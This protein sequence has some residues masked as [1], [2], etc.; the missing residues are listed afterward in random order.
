MK[1]LFR[2]YYGLMKALFG[3]VCD[4]VSARL[5][6]RP[7]RLDLP[8]HTHTPAHTHRDPADALLAADSRDT[9]PKKRKKTLNASDASDASSQECRE[10]DRADSRRA[11]DSRAAHLKKRKK[12]LNDSDASESSDASSQEGRECDAAHV[13][14][15][16]VEAAQVMDQLMASIVNDLPA[17]PPA[18]PPTAVGAP[19]ANTRLR[20]SQMRFEF[21]RGR[22]GRMQQGVVMEGLE[23][24]GGGVGGGGGG[25]EGGA[26]AVGEEEEEEEEEDR[27]HADDSVGAAAGMAGSGALVAKWLD[28]SSRLPVLVARLVV[29]LMAAEGEHADARKALQSV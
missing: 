4:E 1:E 10:E 13:A 3:Q 23:G 24:G 12:K 28:S 19:L 9:Q 7:P 14:R 26:A 22:G 17:R 25:G 8:L 29:V 16:E 6:T 20:A 15:A 21:A 27:P 11:A 2:L 5:L 18:P